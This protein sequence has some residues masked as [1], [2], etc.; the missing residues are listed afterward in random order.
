MSYSTL[1]SSAII[2]VETFTISTPQSD[3]DDLRRLI[4]LSRIPKATYENTQTEDNFGITREWLVKA[5]E[6]WLNL[7]WGAQEERINRVPAFIG[8]V[9]N[10]DGREYKVH[11]A[12]LFSK[13]KDASAVVMLHGW[14][15][16]F[17]EF[18]PLLEHVKSKW[19][20]EDLP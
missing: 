9:K 1:P 6:E 3:L 4:Q 15:G 11:F 10:E 8:T 12:A 18:L 19:S 2:P 14:P 7:D 13:K 5:K 17:L 20:E 16:C